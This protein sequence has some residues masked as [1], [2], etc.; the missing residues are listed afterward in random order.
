MTDTSYMRRAL[1]HAARAQ[2]ATSPNPVVGAVVVSEG[3][4]VVGQG[5]H[6]RAGGP[7]AEVH[8]LDEAGERAR[9]ATLYVT[10]EPCCH[11][12]RTGP[13]TARIIAAG[14]ARVVAATIDL[15][16]L[17]RGR[18]LE[19]LR[20]RGVR[21]D[22]GVE[23]QAALRLNHAFVVAHTLQRP[24]VILKAATSIDGY[25]AAAP[26]VRT[27]LTSL[28][29]ARQTHLLRASVDA[30]GVG[31]ETVRIDDPLLTV[32]ECHRSRPL[33][34]VVF[35]RRL[36]T[37]ATARLFSTLDEGPVIILS[38]E[39]GIADYPDRVTDLRAAGAQ[40]E[41]T[42]GGLRGA[43]RRL[44]ALG[45]SSLLVEGGAAL[46]TAFWAE[47]LVDR[48]HL[49]I[50]PVFIGR[51]GVPLGAESPAGRN[52]LHVVTVE[53]RGHDTWIEADVHGNR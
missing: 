37:R 45:V 14:I 13:C 36:R 3:G 4:V 35:D 21:V 38:S 40:V 44:G 22:V 24:E 12:G 6:E 30:I 7:H 52:S 43:V 49:I 53:P 51:G 16:P 50:A 19:E 10:L 48:M 28:Q 23:E 42:T 15:N 25:I 39:Q 34:R 5:R 2:G 31:S 33:T 26:G 17:V 8:A 1:F 11:T 29:A 47:R 32:R 20:S 46:H 27:Q 41:G 18:G 9:G